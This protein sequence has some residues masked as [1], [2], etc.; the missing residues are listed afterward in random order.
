M[1]K[2]KEFKFKIIGSKGEGQGILSLYSKN[3]TSAK[4]KARRW[5]KWVN[6][7]IYYRTGKPRSYPNPV[8]KTKLLK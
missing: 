7:D 2:K 8:K 4:V 1:I 5:V 3:P 6:K